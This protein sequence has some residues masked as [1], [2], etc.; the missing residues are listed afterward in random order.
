VN[1]TEVLLNN[2]LLYSASGKSFFNALLRSWIGEVPHSRL[3]QS[4][5]L[6][7]EVD[8]VTTMDSRIS[9]FESTKTKSDRVGL[10]SNWKAAEKAIELAIA[11]AEEELR[12]QKVQEEAARRKAEADRKKREEERKA[13]QLAAEKARKEAEQ[14]KAKEQTSEQIQQAVEAQR[15]AERKAAELERALE[16]DAER[17]QREAIALQYVRDKYQWEVLRDVYKRVSYPEWARQFEQEGVVTVNF[18]VGSQGQLLGITSVTPSDSGLLGQEL[19]DAV[20]RA[21]PFNAFPTQITDRQLRV[22]VDYE[23]TLADRVAELPD[24]PAA[25]NGFE[26]DSDL[27]SVQKAVGWA[28]YKESAVSRLQ[29]SIEYPFWAQDLKQEGRVTAEVTIRKDGTISKVSITEKSR[30]K[31]LN[32][33]VEQ[34][35]D[36]VGSVEPFPSWVEDDILTVL[37][38]HNFEL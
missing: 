2:E 13:A 34:A 14:A 38:E 17:Q 37:V 12:Q 29:S 19:R 3:F 26:A 33:E 20:T 9:R 23:F 8:L 16:S 35:M 22:S 6:G 36:R 5:I 32:Q 7:N 18:L 30:H 21:A 1:G 24:A 10:V 28:K 15:E 4:Q 27:T 11:Q 25:P 31:I